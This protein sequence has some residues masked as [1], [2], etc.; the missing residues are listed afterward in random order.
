VSA[1][2]DAARLVVALVIG[3]S[4]IQPMRYGPLSVV[5]V[6]RLRET[7]GSD[8]TTPASGARTASGDDDYAGAGLGA[9]MQNMGTGSWP[10]RRA[11]MSPDKVAFVYQD[12]A[13]TYADV[14]ERST[15]LAAQLRSLGV[16]RGDRVAYLGPNHPA[17]P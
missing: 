15:R 14:C 1:C 2:G 4:V 12:E 16:R 7:R 13:L 10:A 6:A 5:C 9:T 8:L 11:R 3:P 17:F